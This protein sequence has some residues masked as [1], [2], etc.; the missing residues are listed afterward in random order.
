VHYYRTGLPT[1]VLRVGDCALQILETI[2]GQ[3]FTSV[4]APLHTLSKNERQTLKKN[5]NKWWELTR[6]KT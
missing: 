1:H 5:V 4:A 6:G 2:S 3:R